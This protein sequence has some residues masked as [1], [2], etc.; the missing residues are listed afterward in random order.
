MHSSEEVRLFFRDNGDRLEQIEN[1]PYK[2]E[3]NGIEFCWALAKYKYRNKL[4]LKKLDGLSFSNVELVERS[5][6]ELKNNSVKKCF[7]K[8]I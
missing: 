6:N 2:P 5:L 8:G 7:L 3:F 4:L 1:V